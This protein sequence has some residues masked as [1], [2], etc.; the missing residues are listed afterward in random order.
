MNTVAELNDAELDPVWNKM[1]EKHDELAKFAHG[2]MNA[3]KNGLPFIRDLLMLGFDLYFSAPYIYLTGTGDKAKFLTLVRL[4]RKYGHKPTIPSKGA[5]EAC[6]FVNLG[7]DVEVFVRFTSTV[8][9]RV[10]VG[11]KMEEVAVYETQCEEFVGDEVQE[12]AG[13]APAQLEDTLP[14]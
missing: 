10:K 4:H 6:W 9:K 3:K 5:T 2:W 7:P 12:L 13:P 1:K 8:C 11:T 14:F